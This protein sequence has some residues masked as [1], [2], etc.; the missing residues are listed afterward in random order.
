MRT[1]RAMLLLA[2][3]SML[4]GCKPSIGEPDPIEQARQAPW[5]YS[6]YE[7]AP[8]PAEQPARVIRTDDRLWHA[9]DAPHRWYGPGYGVAIPGRFLRPIGTVDDMALYVR[10]WDES[11]Y[12]RLYA[13]LGPDRW[14]EYRPA[15]F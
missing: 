8:S 5:H 12:G 6:V 11:P 1:T 14:R 10:V 13:P 2:A 4:V 7:M 9:Y 15:A 3:G